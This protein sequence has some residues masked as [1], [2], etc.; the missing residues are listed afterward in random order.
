MRINFPS[1]RYKSTLS[2]YPSRVKIDL[3][4]R[5][6][7]VVPVPAFMQVGNEDES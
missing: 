2:S 5:V 3:S 7:V 4:A 1:N 6:D